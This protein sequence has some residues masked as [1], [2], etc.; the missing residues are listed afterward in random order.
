MRSCQEIDFKVYLTEFLHFND[1]SKYDIHDPTRDRL[2]KVRSLIEYLIGKF[3]AVYTPDKNLSL[4]KELLLWK[5][6]PGFK[7][8]IPNKRSRFRDHT[9]MM[10]TWKGGGGALKFVTCLMILLFL[11]NRSTVHFCRWWG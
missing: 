1:N 7:Q 11:N 4:D 3:K 2:Y 5:G 10:S 8:Y 9:F 6:R